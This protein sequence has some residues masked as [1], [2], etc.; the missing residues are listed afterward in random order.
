MRTRRI[1]LLCIPALF[2]TYYAF[3]RLYLHQRLVLT[4][5]KAREV[6]ESVLKAYYRSRLTGRYW[7]QEILRGR[8]QLK[9]FAQSERIGYYEAI[10]L[11]CNL[12][13]C[14]AREAFL[15]TVGTDADVLCQDL[16]NVRDSQ[17]DRLDEGQRRALS[18]WIDML[19]VL[20]S[21]HDRSIG[22]GSYSNR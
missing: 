2:F 5:G 18:S 8:Q 12:R 9:G 13:N 11:N 4:E 6:A 16:K 1:L 7:E 21:D 15:E 22:T 3:Y 10:L 17:A 20:T 14:D 19:S